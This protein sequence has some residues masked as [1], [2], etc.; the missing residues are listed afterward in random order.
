MLPTPFS[1]WE[2]LPQGQELGLCL[3]TPP[4]A[5]HHMR[6]EELTRVHCS[7]SQK[8]EHTPVPGIKISSPCQGLNFSAQESILILPHLPE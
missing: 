6:C 7:K 3:R 8:S 1:P 2:R 5:Q 4:S